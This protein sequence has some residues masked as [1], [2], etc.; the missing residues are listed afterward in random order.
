MKELTQLV[1][2]ARAGDH[3]AYEKIVRRF[4]DMAVGYG[5][6]VLRDM[7]L[8]EDAAQEAFVNAYA[9]L[10]ALQ[11]PAAFPGWFRRIVHK[12]VD[13]V[14]RRRCA[15]VH[16]DQMPEM[17]SR[18]MNSMVRQPRIHH[19]RTRKVTKTLPTTTTTSRTGS[20]A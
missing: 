1:I 15:Y 14:R 10:P 16:L 9:D 3:V 11:D 17:V 20:K 2:S 6:A 12:Q 4:Q 13:R 18:T 19:R 5:F 8:A 7:H